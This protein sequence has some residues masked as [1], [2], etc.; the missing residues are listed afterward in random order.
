MSAN[1]I[2]SNAGVPNLAAW[3]GSPSTA[4]LT[5]ETNARIAADTTLQAQITASSMPSTTRRVTYLAATT[6]TALTGIGDTGAGTGT[7]ANGEMTF[8]TGTVLNNTANCNGTGTYYNR[9]RNPKARFRI[10]LSDLVLRSTWVGLA[11]A[12]LSGGAA[13]PAGSRFA[14]RYDTTQGDATWKATTKDGAT[15]TVVDTGVAPLTARGQYLDIVVDDV[16]A[17]AKFYING[18]LV[19]TIIT[20]LPA[21]GT[22]LS[23]R[24]DTTHLVAGGVATATTVQQ[25]VAEID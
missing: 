14:F 18:V 16:G 7:L 4:D 15:Q 24:V 2:G 21:A 25:I 13:D 22:A 12:A 5:T 1:N 23:L 10:Y 19:A 9:S 17:N 6:G 8:T 20:N 11:S 3:P